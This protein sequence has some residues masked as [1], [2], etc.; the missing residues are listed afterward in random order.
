LIK[1]FRP[2]LVNRFDGVVIFKPLQ[3]SEMSFIAKLGI[4]KTKKLLTDQKVDLTI[5]DKALAE[6]S[7]EGYDPVYGARPLRRLIQT[8]IENPIAVELISK[9]FVAGDTI[10][11]DYDEQNQKFTFFKGQAQPNVQN[12]PNVTAS[13]AS[14]NA[15]VSTSNVAEI[16]IATSPASPD[17]RNDETQNGHSSIFDTPASLDQTPPEPPQPPT[18]GAAEAQATADSSQ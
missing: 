1:F 7:K 4:E 9:K 17:P 13:S 6:L 3:L 10:V 8:A 2:E 5:T 15:A 11:V 12:P 18:A 16:G 14:Q